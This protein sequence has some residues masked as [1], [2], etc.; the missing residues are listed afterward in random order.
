MKK[1]THVKNIFL[2]FT[3]DFITPIGYNQGYLSGKIFG[4]A[5]YQVKDSENKV[6]IVKKIEGKNNNFKIRFFC[7]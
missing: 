3:A 4:L 5:L 7:D 1:I 2:N 6:E